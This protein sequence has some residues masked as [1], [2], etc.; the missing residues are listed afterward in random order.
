[1]WGGGTKERTKE[2]HHYLLAGWLFLGRIDHDGPDD[3]CEYQ[4]DLVE[5]QQ[6]K[7]EGF[8][9]VGGPSSSRV[10]VIKLNIYRYYSLKDVI[11]QYGL[12]GH[13]LLCQAPNSPH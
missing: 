10:L 8:A 2:M 13:P 1:M 4:D 3:I 6:Y 7:G 11:R 12:F 9:V 5:Q